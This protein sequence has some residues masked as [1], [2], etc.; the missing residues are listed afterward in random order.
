[1][2]G[3]WMKG[4]WAGLDRAYLALGE[5]WHSEYTHWHEETITRPSAALL[6]FQLFNDCYPSGNL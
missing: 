3:H 2:T 5:R 1:M 4:H 6:S